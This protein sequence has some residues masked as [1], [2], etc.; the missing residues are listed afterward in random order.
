MDGTEATLN[1]VMVAIHDHK[2][3]L[4]GH[5]CLVEDRSRERLLEAQLIEMC[6]NKPRPQIAGKR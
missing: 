3:R 4:M 2:S 1:L 6:S 5:H